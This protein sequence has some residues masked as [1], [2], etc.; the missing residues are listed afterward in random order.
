[1][2]LW[3]NTSVLPYLIFQKFAEKI[4]F[5]VFFLNFHW[6]G[7]HLCKFEGIFTQN[8]YQDQFFTFTPIFKL[9]DGFCF[10]NKKILLTF[11]LNELVLRITGRGRGIREIK[12]KSHQFS[13]FSH[14]FTKNQKQTKKNYRRSKLQITRRVRQS[15]KTYSFLNPSY[16]APMVK[17]LTIEIFLREVFH[18]LVALFS[19]REWKK[20]CEI[21]F[22]YPA[23]ALFTIYEYTSASGLNPSCVLK[24]N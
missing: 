9:F 21:F 1:M 11:L 15:L 19:S 7:I 16:T 10:S 23:K 20:N 2:K 14:A 5:L 8:N 17:Q 24:I 12:T 22:L 13:F 3:I 4:V 6:N 18:L